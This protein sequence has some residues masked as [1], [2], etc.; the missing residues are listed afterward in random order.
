MVQDANSASTIPNLQVIIFFHEEYYFLCMLI[1]IKDILALGKKSTSIAMAYNIL[2]EHH[3]THLEINYMYDMY[4]NFIVK[5]IK[6]F[7]EN[8][9]YPIWDLQI[10]HFVVSIKNKIGVGITNI[11]CLDKKMIA[12]TDLSAFSVFHQWKVMSIRN[13][14]S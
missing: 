13:S 10:N 3:M 9:W 7:R 11:M 8:T 12:V 1:Y 2:K 5:N 6:H 14:V 4:A